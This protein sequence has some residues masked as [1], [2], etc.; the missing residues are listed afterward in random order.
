MRKVF[1]ILVLLTVTL[2]VHHAM[3]WI[4]HILWDEVSFYKMAREHDLAGKLEAL[5]DQGIASVYYFYVVFG[6]FSNPTWALRVAAL[7]SIWAIACVLFHVFTRYCNLPPGL[8]IGAATVTIV[9]PSYQMYANAGAAIYIISLAL[10]CL[11][12]SCYFR[13]VCG[14]EGGQRWWLAVATVL[15][16]V[17]FMQQWLL[18]WFYGLFAAILVTRRPSWWRHQWHDTTDRAML[19][20]LHLLWFATPFL[21]YFFQRKLFPLAPQFSSYSVPKFA[22]EKNFIDVTQAVTASLG[23][24][25][26]RALE[27]P[28]LFWSVAAIGGCIGLLLLLLGGRWDTAAPE[29]GQLTSGPRLFVAGIILLTAGLFPFVATGKPSA[30][31]GPETRFSILV[32]P[33]LSVIAAGY[34][35][36]IRPM[37]VTLCRNLLAILS[38][39]LLAAFAFQHAQNYI[40][41][42]ACAIKDHAIVT[43]LRR[44]PAP[45]R[46]NFF[47][48]SGDN[49]E[50]TYVRRHYDW[51][52]ILYDAWGGGERIAV[53]SSQWKPVPRHHYTPIGISRDQVADFA[54]WMGYGNPGPPD[55]WCTIEFDTIPEF[56]FSAV[57]PIKVVIADLRH[58][59][60]L[61]S[62]SRQSW[63]DKFVTRVKISRP[64]A[65][66]YS[67]EALP[68]QTFAWSNTR[69][70]RP[71]NQQA[72]HSAGNS[73]IALQWHDSTKGTFSI[74]PLNKTGFAIRCDALPAQDASA[75]LNIKIDLIKS[76][77]PNSSFSGPHGITCDY[78]I[79][80][81][82]APPKLV[83]VTLGNNFTE[84]FSPYQNAGSIE[85]WVEETPTNAWL[86]WV[87]HATGQIIHIQRLKVGQTIPDNRF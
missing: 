3:L 39:V 63:L 61:E 28:G 12:T 85:A 87:P 30:I 83:W 81:E 10:F 18:P 21:Y 4:D 34:I 69:S 45:V 46:V 32:A 40:D 82:S 27:L 76:G 50:H 56:D 62:E 16:V 57:G 29:A 15:W 7:L 1:P 8:A 19:V 84:G 86:A 36:M 64:Q 5:I 22:I 37:R 80:G 53:T 47:V 20:R 43:A 71:L 11:G 26:Y 25:F 74:I 54:R 66:P 24:P 51:G 17:S 59:L 44:Y 41:W 33:S 42:Q 48:I 6:W 13:G 38:L 77:L 73:E 9:Y 78:S 52:R 70:W 14:Q 79:I 31:V 55:N 68:S 35:L 72:F 2:A 75:I 49:L 60:D 23:T 58:R 65:Y 67:S